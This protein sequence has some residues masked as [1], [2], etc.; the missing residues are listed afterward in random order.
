MIQDAPLNPVERLLALEIRSQRIGFA[1][2]DGPT[3]LLDWEIG[4][5]LH[6]TCSLHDIVAKRVRPL[7][8]RYRPFVVVMRCDNHYSSQSPARLRISV[9]RSGEKRVDAESIFNC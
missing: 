4:T 5:L 8:S 2:F 9:A 3:R 6:P 7:L 1:V